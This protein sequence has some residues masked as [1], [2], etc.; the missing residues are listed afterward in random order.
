MNQLKLFV[1]LMIKLKLFSTFQLKFLRIYFNSKISVA[2]TERDII[3]RSE[4]EE[5]GLF[6]DSASASGSDFHSF[7][8]KG[9][10]DVNFRGKMEP[11][12]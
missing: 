9:L 5:N 4:F 6:K 12:A 11:K 7:I 2:S 1:T 8:Q 10:K 3:L